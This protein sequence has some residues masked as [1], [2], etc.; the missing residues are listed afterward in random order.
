MPLIPVLQKC[1]QPDQSLKP[2]RATQWSS[3]NSGK[4]SQEMVVHTFNPSTLDAEAGGSLSL[5]SS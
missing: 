1:K 3:I 2:A 5:R 4:W